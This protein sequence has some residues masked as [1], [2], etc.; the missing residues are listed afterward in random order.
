MLTANFFAIKFPDT[1]IHHY[2]VTITEGSSV[3]KTPKE[4]NR[5][6]I[7]QMAYSNRKLF[8]VRPV[9]DGKKNLYSKNPLPFHGQVSLIL[10]ES[11]LFIIS[12]FIF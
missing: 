5:R 7:E 11:Y 9:F 12:I 6:L 2:D 10:V 1:D 8:G 4:V 3:D